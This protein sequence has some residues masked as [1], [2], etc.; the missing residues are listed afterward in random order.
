MAVAQALAGE[1]CS[2][3]EHNCISR[4]DGRLHGR[5][6]CSNNCSTKRA[7]RKHHLEAEYA[8]YAVSTALGL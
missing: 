4:R 5:C 2:T 3:A 7:Q 8:E 6:L 1:S